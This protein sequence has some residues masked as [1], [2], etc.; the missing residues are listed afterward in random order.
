MQHDFGLA[1]DRRVRTY[2]GTAMLFRGRTLMA[3][4]KKDAA[5]WFAYSMA[6]FYFPPT[7]E[8]KQYLIEQ[9]KSVDEAVVEYQMAV[10]DEDLATWYRCEMVFPEMDLHQHIQNFLA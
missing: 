9:V 8:Q 2:A 10:Y 1:T 4:R 6:S 7:D 5:N 3:L